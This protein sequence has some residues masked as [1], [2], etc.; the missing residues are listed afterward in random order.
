VFF[1]FS[2]RCYSCFLSLCK[3]FE[4]QLGR[5]HI[6]FARW[7]GFVALHERHPMGYFLRQTRSCVNPF[8]FDVE[9]IISDQHMPASLDYEFAP[10]HFSMVIPGPVIWNGDVWLHCVLLSENVN[11]KLLLLID[12]NH[13]QT[14]QTGPEWVYIT[15]ANTIIWLAGASTSDM[16]CCHRSHLIWAVAIAVEHHKAWTVSLKR[17]FWAPSMP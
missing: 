1:S 7:N 10:S 9:V 4:C 2:F 11:T 3:V 13:K 5:R 16:S 12:V 6:S 8:W 14:Y 17:S 15:K